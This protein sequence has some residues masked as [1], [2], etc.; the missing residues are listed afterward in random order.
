M[1][2]FGIRADAAIFDL[3]DEAHQKSSLTVTD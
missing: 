1:S 3:A 2:A